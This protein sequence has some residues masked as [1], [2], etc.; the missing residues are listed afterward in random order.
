MATYNLCAPSVNDCLYWSRHLLFSYYWS[1]SG[2][3]FS[4]TAAVFI[5]TDKN[6]PAYP[7]YLNFLMRNYGLYYTTAALKLVLKEASHTNIFVILL[8]EWWTTG[9][10][11]RPKMDVDIQEILAL[12]ALHYT[13]T[14]ISEIVKISRSTLYRRLHDAGISTD[15]YLSISPTKLD[16]VIKKI[17]SH[18]PNDG[19]VMLKGYFLRLGLKV[20]R[21]DLRNSIHHV[22]HA[23]TIARRSTIIQRRLYTVACPNAVWRMDS[24]HKLIDGFHVQFC[25]LSA[26]TI[27]KLPLCYLA[28]WMGYPYIDCL[29]M[30]AQITVERKL[31]GGNIWYLLMVEIHPVS[32]QVAQCTMNT[33]NV[34]GGMNIEVWQLHMLRYFVLLKM[35]V[36]STHL[37][38]WIYICI[39]SSTNTEIFDRVS[40]FMELPFFVYWRLKK[41]TSTL[42]L[43]E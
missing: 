25:M 1:A 20:T 39:L 33:L 18:F 2:L 32:W 19:E 30:S 5:H 41:S 4:I 10:Q 27:T 40:N 34:S 35:T 29:S 28:F 7:M 37:M 14:K 21:Q 6:I 13:W 23:N 9:V 24:H 8:Q 15:D 26:V 31:K 17:R 12:R 16:E 42:F 38:R 43:R 11:N 36:C 22:D 3:D